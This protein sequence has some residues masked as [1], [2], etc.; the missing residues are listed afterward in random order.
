MHPC[1]PDIILHLG[2]AAGRTFYTLE[3]QSPRGPYNQKKDV[4]GKIFTPDENQAAWSTCPEMLKPTFDTE[5]VWRRWRSH[6][7][8]LGESADAR[9][10]DDPGNF[11]CGFIYYASMAWFWKRHEWRGERPVMFLHVPDCP[12]E[13]DVQVGREVA[14]GLVRALVESRVAKGVY[15]PLSGVWE[16]D[17][18]MGAA[19]I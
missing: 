14:I 5:D 15:E 16:K 12:T 13:K 2:L 18:V 6:L 8:P 1:E 19:E 4:D 9:P 3:R 11:L 7:L 17:V 10:S